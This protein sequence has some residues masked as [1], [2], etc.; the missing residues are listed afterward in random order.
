M[1]FIRFLN[2]EKPYILLY[3]L[4][5]FI[6][7][8]FYIIDPD[9]YFKWSTFI[10][11]FVVTV[12]PMILFFLFR[13]F[14]NVQAV[15]QMEHEDVE[16][17][18]LEA[19]GYLQRMEEM[20]RNQIRALNEIRAKQKDYY[21]FIVT[22]FHEI[23]TPISVL[24]LM[25]QTELDKESLREEVTKIEHYVDQAL[26]YAK[27]DSFNQDYEIR[28][29]DL[30]RLVKDIIKEHS[31][32]FITK[33]IRIELNLQS[34]TVQSDSKWLYF[35]INQIL[36]NSLQY[37]ANHGEIVIETIEKDKGKQLIIRDNGMGIEQ[38]DIP[39][40]FNRGFTGSN[41]RLNTKSTGMGL[42]LAQELSNKLGH[43]I[44]CQS[45]VNVYTEFIIHFPKNVDPYL[46]TV[47]A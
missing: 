6:V 21:D 15:R 42:Y 38:K 28:N 7:S 43:F 41:G 44:T 16:P 13:Y 20:E 11:A 2:Y 31:K 24:R 39:R 33:K 3:F 1:K 35:I 19:A 30:D 4:C 12:I 32:T 37:T 46:D 36:R 22:W 25:Q 14:Q 45:Q 34:T 40:I 18:S 23:K 17:L 10:Y 26:Y 27:L 9:N 47:K 8:A 5:F 29:C